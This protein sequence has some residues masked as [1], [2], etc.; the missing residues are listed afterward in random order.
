MLGILFGNRVLMGVIRSLFAGA[1]LLTCLAG[2]ASA[3]ISVVSSAVD[4]AAATRVS[5][6]GALERAADNLA[7]TYARRGWSR[8][9]QAMDMA[10]SWMG[11]LT[12]GN[13]AVEPVEDPVDAYVRTAGLD[14]NHPEEAA[15]R[16]IVDLRDATALAATVE[17]PADAFLRSEQALDR[18]ALTRAL[19]DVEQSI[20]HTRRAL[21]LFDSTI[22]RL[23]D[24][25]DADADVTLLTRLADERQALSMQAE[26]LSDRADLISRQR[27]HLRFGG[28][29]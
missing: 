13:S 3:P 28:V 11:R 10:G 29:G 24:D 20:V 8:V 19:D 7:M 2:C 5:E 14:L 27:H 25:F 23:S 18:T 21:G 9:D 16:L 26:R 15:A 12:R 17:I 6:S 4:S 22:D 1:C